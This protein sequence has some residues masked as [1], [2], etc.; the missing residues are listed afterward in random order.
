MWL[1]LQQREARDYVISNGEMHT[2]REFVEEAFK[3]V[4][5]SPIKWEG[6]GFNEVGKYQGKIVVRVDNKFFRNAEV[7]SLMGDS[8]KARMELKWKPETS[9][10][11]LVKMMVEEDMKVLAERGVLPSDK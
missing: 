1:M 11:E 8:S 9:F 2:V 4:G 5:M 10:K 7:D 3:C 6:K